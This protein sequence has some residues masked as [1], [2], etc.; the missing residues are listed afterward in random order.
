[1]EDAAGDELVPLPPH[2]GQAME[3]VASA[4]EEEIMEWTVAG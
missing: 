4:T 1:M 2:A 3:A